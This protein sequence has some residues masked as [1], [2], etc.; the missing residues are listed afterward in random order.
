LKPATG[1]TI[2]GK[3]Q[4]T[5]P[6][7]VVGAS[8]SSVTVKTNIKYF[9]TDTTGL[10]PGYDIG[11][12]NGA[13]LDV[14]KH[15]LEDG[16]A[17]N[18][19]IQSLPKKGFE[20]LIIPLGIKTDAVTELTI[21]A[22]SIDL[23][24]DLQI[25]IEDSVLNVFTAL[26]ETSTYTINIDSDMDG[27]GRFYIHTAKTVLSTNNVFGLNDAMLFVKDAATLSISG[28]TS[29]QTNFKDHFRW[30]WGEGSFYTRYIRGCLSCATTNERK[31]IN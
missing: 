16:N 27:I 26:N 22:Y 5:V 15:L 20:D 17:V 29:G 18:Y 12:F 24:A 7:I 13:S 31:E 3:N 9:D 2:F 6:E 30:I 10:D 4:T 1:A 8:N 21:T 25:F 11:N 28:L 19:T 23:P 14:F